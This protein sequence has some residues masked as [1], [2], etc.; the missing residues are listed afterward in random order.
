MDLFLIKIFKNLLVFIFGQLSIF[1]CIFIILLKDFNPV[2]ILDW[3]FGIES[4]QLDQSITTKLSVE[5]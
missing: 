4:D 3:V 5:R 2:K 1:I